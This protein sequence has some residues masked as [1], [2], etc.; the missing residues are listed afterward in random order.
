[1]KPHGGGD[2]GDNSPQRVQGLAGAGLPGYPFTSLNW[3]T[4]WTLVQFSGLIHASSGS[5]VCSAPAAQQ[6]DSRTGAYENRC[7]G[8]GPC[9]R[10]ASR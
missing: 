4:G 1:M 8:D 9:R 7:S 2:E 6:R 5:G 10:S 3:L